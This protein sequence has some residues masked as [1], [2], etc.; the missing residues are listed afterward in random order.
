[1]AEGRCVLHSGTWAARTKHR[2]RHSCHVPYVYQ[3]RYKDMAQPWTENEVYRVTM[4]DAL[5]DVPSLA[6]DK[7]L[8]VFHR[9]GFTTVGHLYAETGQ[10]ARI[11]QA[12]TD[13]RDEAGAAGAA[14]PVIDSVWRGLQTRCFTI[15][16]RIRSAEAHPVP[17]RPLC[18]RLA[19][20]EVMTDP[21]VTKYGFTYE[22]SN[23]MRHIEAY[24]NDPFSGDP[25][26]VDDLV[27]N[28]SLRDAIEYYHLHFMRFAVPLHPRR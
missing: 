8:T 23:I 10:A 13:L 25:L 17:P 21:V 6:G 20:N 18:C 15:I 26:T 3:R 5:A 1:M 16:A 28:H 19:P 27:A 7:T 4:D 24:N 22:R 2:P 14:G 11:R 12:V 9:A